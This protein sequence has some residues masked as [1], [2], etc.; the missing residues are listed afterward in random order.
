MLEFIIELPDGLE[1]GKEWRGKIREGTRKSQSL[2]TQTIEECGKK[3]NGGNGKNADAFLSLGNIKKKLG[4]IQTDS[5][6]IEEIGQEIFK[7]GF[8]L[9]RYSI[10]KE[11][12]VVSLE[13]VK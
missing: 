6:I 3:G 2:L 4:K 13:G 8:A 7:H 9:V 1:V 10:E 11:Y 5:K 12:L